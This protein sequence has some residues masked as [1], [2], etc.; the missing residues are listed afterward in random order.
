M[1]DSF[2]E[3]DGGN[4]AVVVLSDDKGL[5][6]ADEDVYRKLVDA[7]RADT[8]N[9]KSTQDFVAI[10]ELRP[11]MTSK[12]GKAWTLPSQPG[13]E[14]GHRARPALLQARPGD[15]QDRPPRDR[16]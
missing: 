11:T 13:R 2:K 3:A 4:I 5:S 16:R 10:P 1:K 12:D 8:A 7:L 14:H 15:G 6:K 9:V